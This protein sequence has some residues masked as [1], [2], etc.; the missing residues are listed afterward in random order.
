MGDARL[1]PGQCGA[2]Q[3]ER[4]TPQA[5]ACRPPELPCK[6]PPFRF[7]HTA[8]ATATQ[9]ADQLISRLPTLIQHP[10]HHS[11]QVAVALSRENPESHSSQAAA[12][13]L[14]AMHPLDEQG[15][16]LPV[17]FRVYP[18]KH[19]L[20]AADGSE[21]RGKVEE[22]GKGRVPRHSLQQVNAARRRPRRHGYGC[23]AHAHSVHS[24]S[25]H[26]Q[27]FWGQLHG[28]TPTGARK[29]RRGGGKRSRRGS[30]A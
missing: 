26:F 9:L 23:R 22:Q 16:Q 2:A 30:H 13:F 3:L 28:G 19:L 21:Q 12:S 6:A 20:R 7:Q 1:Q 27:Q 10:A 29:V 18:P 15:M 24:P 17:L 14:Q 25:E 11:T 5:Q 8:A 4:H